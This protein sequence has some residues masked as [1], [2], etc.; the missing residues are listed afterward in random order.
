MASLVAV[1]GRLAFSDLL[2]LPGTGDR[3]EKGGWGGEEDTWG[4]HLWGGYQRPTG[5]L[6]IRKGRARLVHTPS[7]LPG[8]P[9]ELTPG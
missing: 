3:M 1:P 6:A 7:R 5:L 2:P 4:G 8:S 9:F